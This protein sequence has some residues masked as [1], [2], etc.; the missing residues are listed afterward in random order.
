MEKL[1]NSYDVVVVY[2]LVCY[3]ELPSFIGLWVSIGNFFSGTGLVNEALNPYPIGRM[4]TYYFRKYHPPDSFIQFRINRIDIKDYKYNDVCNDITGLTQ[5]NSY[6][7]LGLRLIPSLGYNVGVSDDTG[8]VVQDESV[9]YFNFASD[10]NE[11]LKYYFKTKLLSAY[12]SY[13]SFKNDFNQVCEVPGAVLVSGKL[14]LPVISAY[15]YRTVKIHIHLSIR[16]NN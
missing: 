16:T 13:I 6:P 5:I 1:D 2:P 12:G 7:T 11:N 3:F 14:D 4:L 10:D 9:R 8:I 15:I